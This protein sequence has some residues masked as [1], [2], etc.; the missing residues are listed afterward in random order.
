MEGGISLVEALA[1]STAVFGKTFNMMAALKALTYFGDGNL[2]SL[3]QQIQDHLRTAAER[4]KL[5]ALPQ[6]VAKSGIQRQDL[7][8]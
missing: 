5:E 4:V 2:P 6:I 3:P 8:R 1:A 7:Q